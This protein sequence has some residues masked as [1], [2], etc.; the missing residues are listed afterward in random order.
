MLNRTDGTLIWYYAPGFT[1]DDDIH[2]Y[3][4]TSIVS[5]CIVINKQ[6]LTSANG[7]IF[8]LSLY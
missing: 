3:L 1:I 7:E 4:T 8:C 2:N 6:V 5:D